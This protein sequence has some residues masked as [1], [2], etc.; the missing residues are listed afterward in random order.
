MS[1]VMS[2][3]VD[4]RTIRITSEQDRFR[5]SGV[6]DKYG[7][8]VMCNCNN[9]QLITFVPKSFYVICN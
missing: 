8:F 6:I 7:V 1:A 2:F 3:G 4:K 9:L 5:E